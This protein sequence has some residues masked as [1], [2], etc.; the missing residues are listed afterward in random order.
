VAR[1]GPS[2][3]LQTSLQDLLARRSPV[4]ALV[5]RWRPSILPASARFT[6]SM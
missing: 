1:V 5:S 4:P 6:L 2:G 3:L